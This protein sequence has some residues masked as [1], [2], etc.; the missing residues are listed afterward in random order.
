VNDRDSTRWGRL[1]AL[2]LLEL[3]VVIALCAALT[4][5]SL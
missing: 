4:H 5:V 2:A 1:Y 3:A